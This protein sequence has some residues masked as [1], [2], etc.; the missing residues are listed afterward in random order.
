MAQLFFYKNM[1]LSAERI[2]V[3]KAQEKIANAVAIE[4]KEEVEEKVQEK[5]EVQEK[6]VE[7]KTLSRKKKR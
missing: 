7:K 6:V 4:V 5:V 1:M 3:L 2:N